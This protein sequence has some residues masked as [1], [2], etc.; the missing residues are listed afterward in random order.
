METKRLEAF[1]DGVLAVII[2]IM[3][4]E[5][6]QP[7]GTNLHDLVKLW[8]HFLVYALSFQLIGIYWNNHHQ[9]FRATKHINASVMWLNLLLLFFLSLVPFFTAWFGENHADK[10]PTACF[11]AVL[12]AASVAYAL[13]LQAIVRAN[14]DDQKL[15]AA[16]SHDT[17]G[18]ISSAI[19]LVAIPLAF[20]NSWISIGLYL[21]VACIWFIPDRRLQN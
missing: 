1:S 4:L 10:I 11:G 3:V 17:K 9:M 8:P 19:Y 14:K 18:V 5:L 2:T 13:L 20:I 7:A 16:V 15:L 6:N 12:F 21:T